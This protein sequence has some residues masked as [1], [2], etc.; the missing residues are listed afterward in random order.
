MIHH[1]NR[2][3][4]LKNHVILI[5]AEKALCKI[6]KFLMKNTLNKLGI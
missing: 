2:T 1:I 5:Y 4:D 3:N 6:Q